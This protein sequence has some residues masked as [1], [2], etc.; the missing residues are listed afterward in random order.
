MRSPVVW[1][2]GLGIRGQVLSLVAVALTALAGFGGLYLTT[3]SMLLQATA[4]AESFT[5]I[6]QSNADLEAETLQMRRAEKDF[7]LRRDSKYVERY[8]ER[9][10]R[11]MKALA[12]LSQMLE[13]TSM[14]QAMETVAA[15]VESH[16]RQFGLVSDLVSKQGLSEDVG[17]RGSLRG[18]VHDVEKRLSVLEDNELL[19]KMLMMRRH[20]KDFMLRGGDKYIARVDAR[21]AEFLAILDTRELPAQT[22]ADIVASLDTYVRDFKAFAANAQLLA[23]ETAKLSQIFAEMQPARRAIDEAAIAG[24]DAALAALAQARRTAHVSMA[25]GAVVI[26][27]ALLLLSAA[28]VRGMTGP[29]MRLVDAMDSLSN[30]DTDCDLDGLRG[31]REVKRMVESVKVFRNNALERQRLEA[32][33]RQAH[34]AR[35]QRAQAIEAMISEFD[36]QANEALGVVSETASRM[37]GSARDMS[38]IA[39]TTSQRSRTVSGASEEASANVQTVAS[40]TEELTVSVHEITRQVRE[41]G[42]VAERA[43][44]QTERATVEVRGLVEASQKIG[45]IVNLISD[46]ASQTNL[47]A[48]NATIEAARAGAAGKGF[49]V[50]ASEVK[51]LAT[52]TAKA[53]EDI[54]AQIGAIQGATGAAVQEIEGIGEVVKQVNQIALAISSAID[55]QGS[56]TSEI[57]HNVQEA[58]AGIQ[59]VT[60]NMARV[61]EEAERTGQASNQVL[62][63]TEQLTRQAERLGGQVRQFL[64]RVRAA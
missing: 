63:A 36:Q 12:A 53:T 55:Q 24:K 30:G 59:D 7:L 48:L 4:T 50:V 34:E 28:V 41:S 5:R 40:A 60:D 25:V 46:I 49:A 15:G 64:D 23:V 47:L 6:A 61:S 43:V 42:T 54:A 39:A 3:Q 32:E 13:A 62:Q 51:T 21:K 19:V 52:Q 35:E 44:H 1:F 11:A 56:A 16:R 9:A 20:E 31:N 14:R 10:D 57:S 26:V 29:I 22:R 2:R 17:L 58:A 33:Q 37:E 18:A 8:N 27:V 38:D 45:D